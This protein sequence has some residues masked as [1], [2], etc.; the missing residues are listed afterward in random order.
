[1]FYKNFE[2][3]DYPEF[4]DEY[5]MN[6]ALIEAKKAYD[7]GEVPIGA[8]V[9]IE[10]KIIARAYNQTEM[11]NDVTAHAEILAITSAEQYLGAK[12]L[13]NA[14]LYVTVEP[15]IM[16]IGAI[17]WSKLSNLVYGAKDEKFGHYKIEQYIENYEVSLYHPKLQVKSGIL[18]DEASLLMENF[19]RQKRQ[20]K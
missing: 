3:M 16:C 15:C 7:K 9:V 20:L 10:N 17:F 1:M 18:A 8:I 2:K 5:F 4:S 11:L 6:F 14:S 19:F 13:T 12:Y